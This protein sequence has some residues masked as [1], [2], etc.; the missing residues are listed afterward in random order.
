MNAVGPFAETCAGLAAGLAVALPCPPDPRAMAGLIL[1]LVLLGPLTVLLFVL[2]NRPIA[3]RRRDDRLA[4]D[5]IARLKARIVEPRV[6]DAGLAG[7]AP[8]RRPGNVPEADLRFPANM[9]SRPMQQAPSPA[10]GC[11][12]H[13]QGWRSGTRLAHWRCSTCGQESASLHERH[14]PVHCRSASPR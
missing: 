6:P 2:W 14:P 12:W 5:R 11:R 9:P 7:P 10:T 3:S 13:Y 1:S 8:A 4:A